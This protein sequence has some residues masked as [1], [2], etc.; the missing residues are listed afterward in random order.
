LEKKPTSLE[1][2]RLSIIDRGRGA[3]T[4][5]ELLVA[6]AVVSFLTAISLPAL[7]RAK[8]QARRVKSMSNQRQIV[9]A[10]NLY[11]LDNDNRYPES[12]ATIGSATNWNWQEPFVLTSIESRAPHLHRAMSEYLGDY[13]R[14]AGMMVCPNAPKRYRHLQE[15]W[16][17]GDRWNNPDTWLFRD[18]VKGTYC[19]YW[20]YT[21][22]LAD[23]LFQG[24]RRLLGGRG[25]SSLMVTCYLGYDHWRS[26]D[27]F[28]SCQRFTKARLTAEGVASS[29]YWSRLK[30]DSCSL[31]TINAR[32]HAAYTDGHVESFAAREA[33]TMKVIKDRFTNQPYTYGPG[34]FYLPAGELW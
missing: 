29:A 14:D 34:D 28:G 2:W 10:V 25:Q 27:S 5:L 30:S 17:A 8:R 18:W 11:A 16:Q 7:S 6:L 24:P 4:L 26:P 23:R 22:L 1:A 3:F 21:G 33:A 32:P 9:E 13:I 15:A 31:D 20:N 19:F 12:V